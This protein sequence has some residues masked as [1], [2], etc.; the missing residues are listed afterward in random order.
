MR[1]FDASYERAIGIPDANGIVVAC[2]GERAVNWIEKGESTDAISM[3]AKGLDAL[4]LFPYLD[5]L[6]R[7][8]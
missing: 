3:P 8:G 5:S 6:I 7:R 2:G 4:V 1:I